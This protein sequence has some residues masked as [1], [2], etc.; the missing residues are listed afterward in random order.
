[1]TKDGVF[2]E[3][4]QN[5]EFDQFDCDL[6]KNQT[7]VLIIELGAPT[8]MRTQ[9]TVRTTFADQIANLGYFHL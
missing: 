2:P 4:Y 8:L 9:Q 1:L 3:F 7:A 5:N 6:V